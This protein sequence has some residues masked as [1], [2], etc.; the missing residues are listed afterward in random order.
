M[1]PDPERIQ[2]A[3]VKPQEAIEF[4][5]QS[6]EGHCISALIRLGQ[7]PVQGIHIRHALPGWA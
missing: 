3:L 5:R 4:P 1:K 7:A 2:V 6:G